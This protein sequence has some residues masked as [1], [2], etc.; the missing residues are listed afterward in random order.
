MIHLF[1]YALLAIISLFSPLQVTPGIGVAA[2]AAPL[3]WEQGQGIER[4][5]WIH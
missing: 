3:A 1:F 4:V 5:F 2:E